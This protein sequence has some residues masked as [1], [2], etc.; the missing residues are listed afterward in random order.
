MKLTPKSLVMLAA[1]AVLALLVA[2]DLRPQTEVAPTLP[3]LP[4]VVVD[5]VTR[6]TIGDQIDKLTIERTNKDAPWQIVAP[7]QYPADAKIVKAFVKALASGVPMQTQ[8]DKGNLEDY[9]VDD[10]HA[11]RAELYTSGEEPALAVIVGKTAGPESAFVR[12]PGDDTVYRAE[13][14]ARERFE[15]K[16]GEWRDRTVLEVPVE[17]VVGFTIERGAETLRFTRGASPGNDEKGAPLPGTWT[18]AD[19]PFPVDSDGVDVLVHGVGRVRAGEINNPDYDG[20]FASPAAIATFT[21]KTGATHRIVVGGRSDERACWL[22]VDDRP[23]VF[24]VSA[25][26]KQTLLLPLT[27]LRDRSLAHFDRLAIDTVS[28]I[29]GSLTMTVRWDPSA[30][31]WVV[32]QPANVDV[33]QKEI[34]QATG[35]LASLRA[36]A[37]APDATFTPSGTAVKLRMRDGREWEL[38]LAAAERE[39]KLQR[40]RVS[41]RSE[42]FLVDARLIAEI[43]SAFGR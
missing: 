11:L 7:L 10:Q 32:T 40:A 20:G 1:A 14:G 38:T 22:R 33:D 5:D 4:V 42:V 16:A 24:K 18:L 29:E 28:W 23:E 25:K 2:L 3:S 30:I 6:V 31:K 26:V 9:G 37:F 36:V 35:Q 39:G 43:R 27:E 41:G 13:V 12:L 21:T 19:A 8:V 17:E 15:R 34:I